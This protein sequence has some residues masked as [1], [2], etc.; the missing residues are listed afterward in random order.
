MSGFFISDATETGLDPGLSVPQPYTIWP[1]ANGAFTSS[2]AP[3]LTISVI[4]HAE[5]PEPSS[6]ALIGTLLGGQLLS[7]GRRRSA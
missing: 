7:F 3:Y 5:V 4:A 2:D 1:E 6:I